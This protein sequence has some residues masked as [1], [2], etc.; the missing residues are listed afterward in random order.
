MSGRL[1]KYRRNSEQIR[2]ILDSVD[3]VDETDLEI[4]ALLQRDGRASFNKIAGRLGISVATVSKRV[5]SLRERGIIEGFSVVVKCEL[6]GFTENL[7][8]MVYLEP[9]ADVQK[10]GERLSDLVGVKCIHGIFSDFDLL[11]HLCCAT[12]D[13]IT[14]AIRTIG[15]QD[16]VVKVT[17]MSVNQI[18]KQDFRVIL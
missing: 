16:G 8:L 13:E 17:K 18:I 11:I 7:W 4:I 15:S 6:L 14:E 12:S 5:A 2:K 1:V 10:I 9:S 3:G